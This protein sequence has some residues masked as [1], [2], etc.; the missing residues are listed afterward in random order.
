VQSGE[1]RSQLARS[2]PQCKQA[3]SP[4]VRFCPDDGSKLP[5]ELTTAISSEMLKF[6]GTGRPAKMR[7]E[8][9]K[10]SP[11]AN[12]RGE[13]EKS[14]KRASSREKLE[15]KKKRPDVLD[16][17]QELR[18]LHGEVDTVTQPG[19]SAGG[20][21][22]RQPEARTRE[23]V[24]N[25]MIG[26]TL[27]N[28]YEILSIVGQGGMSVVYKARH[29]M[30][31][32][33]VAIKTLLPHLILHPLSLQRFQQEAQA[34]S[35]IV[36]TNVVT[37]YNFGIT[38]EGQPYLV[39]DYLEGISLQELILEHGHLAIERAVNIFSQMANALGLAHEKGV[40]HRDLK[41]SNII[42]I[43]Q[44][45][46]KDIVQIVDF[47]IAKLL[48]QEGAEAMALTQTGE[49]FGSPLYMSPEQAKGEKLD[50]RSDIYSM[51]C[52]M[53]ESLCGKLPHHGENA[54]EVLYK[55]I[56]DVPPPMSSGEAKI[57]HALEAIVF[58][59]LAKSPDLRYPSML[60]LEEDL[61]SFQKAQQ[62]SLIGIWK[63]RMELARL[64][65]RPRSKA[66]TT[67]RKMAMAFGIL[68]VVGAICGIAYPAVSFWRIADSPTAKQ[69]LTWEEER[70][71]AKV[72]S[73]DLDVLATS[74]VK[75]SAQKFLEHPNVQEFGERYSMCAAA[76]RKLIEE[77]HY[78]EAVTVLNM[79]IK[80]A[81][82]YVDSDSVLMIMAY[83]L[84][85]EAYL[86]MG[87]FPEAAKDYGILIQLYK[88]EAHHQL[89]EE[90]TQIAHIG[91]CYYFMEQYAL[92]AGYYTSAI[93]KWYR[94]E[95]TLPNKQYANEFGLD[96]IP[97]LDVAAMCYSRL[98][99][100]YQKAA[101]G[102]IDRVGIDRPT[103]EYGHAARL[104][105][106]ALPMWRQQEGDGGKNSSLCALRLAEVLATHPQP[107]LKR[108]AKLPGGDKLAQLDKDP[109]SLF[110]RA[111]AAMASKSSYGTSHPY[112]AIALLQHAQYRLSQ[113]DLR[114]YIKLRLQACA[115]L[116]SQSN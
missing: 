99:E 34:A 25:S 68:A 46:R 82:Q 14:H 72:K 84:R 71:K 60:D 83:Q 22:Q 35:N 80:I 61:E 89:I 37:I 53:Y 103:E 28:Q 27:D 42:L 64:K 69:S 75:N 98:G 67:A 78:E 32:K 16:I 12:G 77:A 116:G 66:E 107:D 74:L 51:G 8:T 49:V 41:P 63:S 26:Q 115:I 54:L 88:S 91:D 96:S 45:D 5:E 1:N 40:V 90:T 10:Q 87:K 39:M 17:S 108:V 100:I 18:I 105:Y 114:N 30:L 38:P 36:H 97:K 57:P 79:A 76:A 33:I 73:N 7:A 106:Q 113:H 56:N 81:K 86:N 102:E 59:C 6:T 9:E 70:G 92:A 95:N 112:Y 44:G 55:H 13:S 47:G 109:E 104:F 85:A 43:E 3:Y 65:K 23:T 50:S 110:E 94:A 62:F 52:L 11:A 19:G 4:D 31:R 58:K 24:V 15:N 111:E 29:L 21:D 2:C 93:R 20:G 101:M 48:P